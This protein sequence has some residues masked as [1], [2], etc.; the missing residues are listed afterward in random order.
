MSDW[1]I[2]CKKP[3]AGKLGKAIEKITKEE[4]VCPSSVTKYA[5]KLLKKHKVTKHFLASEIS[6]HHDFHNSWSN[7]DKYTHY[8][9]K[10]NNYA[11][12]S[13][14]PPKGD[15]N[16][17]SYKDKVTNPKEMSAWM[18]GYHTASSNCYDR[19]NNLMLLLTM[20]L[21]QENV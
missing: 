15:R 18:A 1:Y 9:E 14:S 5:E 16:W 4:I 3:M 13:I 2:E 20:Y 6:R 8:S 10:E 19:Y 7:D 12:Q 11:I 21:E 17:H